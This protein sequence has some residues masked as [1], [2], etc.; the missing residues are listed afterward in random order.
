MALS[1]G[2]H[3]IIATNTTLSRDGLKDSQKNEKGGLSGRPLF[4]KSTRVLARMALATRGQVPL[5]GVGG[6]SSA[7]EAMTKLR[8]GATAVQLYSA[9]VYNGISLIPRIAQGL[10]Q[11]LEAG[12][13]SSVADIIGLDAEDWAA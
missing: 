7:E 11:M 9:M 3:A 5:I 6:V 13:H 2:L 10:D 12:G 8:A 4:D 1:A